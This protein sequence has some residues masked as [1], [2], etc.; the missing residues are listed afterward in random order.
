[1]RLPQSSALLL[2]LLLTAIAACAADAP[3]SPSPERLAKT[4]Q[5]IING[6]T[7]T[8][9]Q[10]FVVQIG[11]EVQGKK[12][13]GCSSSLVAPNL[14]LTARHCV[15][16]L[17]PET[18]VVKD[19]DASYFVVYPGRDAPQKFDA[20][21]TPA[22]RG[23]KVFVPPTN[24]LFPDVALI[25]FDRAIDAPLATLRL[26]KPAV[27]NELLVVVGFGMDENNANPPAR[28]Q[29][30]GVRVLDI[31]P[32]RTV[33]HELVEGEF[34]FG[35][36]ACFGDSGGPALSAKTNAVVGVASRVDSG[37]K[38][39]DTNPSAP[40]VGTNTEDV[41][42]ELMLVRDVIETAFAAAGAKP[43]LEADEPAPEKKTT[44]ATEEEA[45]EEPAPAPPRKVTIQKSTG[46]SAAPGSAGSLAPLFLLTASALVATRRRRTK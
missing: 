29:R 9:E 27:K 38:G 37:V 7:S 19:Y 33:F 28:K 42:T 14:V 15:G 32:G 26:T 34:V 39:T 40:C 8:A 10:D 46:C 44:P 24:L 25:L 31:G 4:K 43:I 1:M 22:A 20:D 36:A 6:T 12:Y 2:P 3:A 17:N 16:E 41:Y 11:L 18:A 13:P 35:E 30:T 5:P 45:T 23:K 21:E